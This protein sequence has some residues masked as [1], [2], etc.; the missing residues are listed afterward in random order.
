MVLVIA[1]I[2]PI[3]GWDRKYSI[4]IA[5]AQMWVA[6]L[7]PIGI[8]SFYKRK[9]YALSKIKN[10]ISLYGNIVLFIYTMSLM[11]YSLTLAK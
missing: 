3:L 9:N 11:I 4:Y 5:F 6:I 8:F 2:S 1:I 7:T 10:N